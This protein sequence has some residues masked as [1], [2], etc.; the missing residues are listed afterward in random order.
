MAAGAL[1]LAWFSDLVPLMLALEAALTLYF[2]VQALLNHIERRSPGALQVAAG[3]SL[4][5]VGHLLYFTGHEAG[6]GHQGIGDVLTLVGILLLVQVLPAAPRKGDLAPPPA[7]A[8]S[9]E[10]PPEA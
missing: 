4:F 8:P 9:P 6:R 10:A 5:F 7:E 1:S 3:F 2:A